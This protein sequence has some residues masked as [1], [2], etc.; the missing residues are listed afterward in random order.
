MNYVDDDAH[1]HKQSLV[2][3]LDLQT[4]I[5]LLFQVL[6][7]LCQL[8]QFHKS[9]HPDHLED[10]LHAWCPEKH[11]CPL[12]ALSSDIRGLSSLEVRDKPVDGQDGYNIYQ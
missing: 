1:E 6:F 8:Y 5:E 4:F 3:R 11:V 12:V 2:A 7:V 10:F 9:Q